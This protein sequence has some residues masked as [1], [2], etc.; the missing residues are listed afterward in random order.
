[1]RRIQAIQIS[2]CLHGSTTIHED[3]KLAYQEYLQSHILLYSQSNSTN[4]AKTRFLR[5]H[6]NTQILAGPYLRNNM[7]I[8][9]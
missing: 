2:P 5:L 8:I 9:V 6:S 7:R 3:I 1:M 4:T